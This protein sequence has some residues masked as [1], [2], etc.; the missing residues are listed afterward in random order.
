MDSMCIRKAEMRQAL[1]F[2]VGERSSNCEA[3]H[4]VQTA[5][6]ASL[7]LTLSKP[8]ARQE[9]AKVHGHWRRLAGEVTWKVARLLATLLTPAL[10]RRL[11]SFWSQSVDASSTTDSAECQSPVV[12][13]RASFTCLLRRGLRRS[14]IDVAKTLLEP[15]GDGVRRASG[16]L[17]KGAGPR[18]AHA[19]GHGMMDT[20]PWDHVRYVRVIRAPSAFLNHLAFDRY[21]SNLMLFRS[22]TI[23]RCLPPRRQPR[24]GKYCEQADAASLLSRQETGFPARACHE[25]VESGSKP[26]SSCNFG[27]IRKSRNPT[28]HPRQLDGLP[29][30]I[31]HAAEKLAAVRPNPTS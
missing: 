11:R 27:K 1:M 12:T 19:W 10:A 29:C 21:P 23:L 2:E 3:K 14:G 16:Q 5:A 31:F 24:K 22:E 20:A 26:S 28:L 15:E 6:F 9:G 25:F 17:R 30:R 18:P 7:T 13:C 8:L 4:T